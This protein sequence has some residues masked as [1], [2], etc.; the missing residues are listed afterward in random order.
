MTNNLATSFFFSK[1][2]SKP[3]SSLVSCCHLFVE[4]VAEREEGE[5]HGQEVSGRLNAGVH[6]QKKI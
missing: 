1:C 4:L 3:P 2:F 6:L 5:D